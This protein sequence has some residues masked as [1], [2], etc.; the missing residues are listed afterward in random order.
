MVTPREAKQQILGVWS[1]VDQNVDTAI[2]SAIAA[3][4]K[5]VELGVPQELLD[6]VGQV[7][8]DVSNVKAAND[9][10]GT[11]INISFGELEC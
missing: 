11:Q 8:Q 6:L 2:A 7:V 9:A 5:A 3:N 1:Q 4:Q 10:L